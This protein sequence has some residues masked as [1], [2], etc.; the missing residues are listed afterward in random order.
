M[1]STFTPAL[2][3]E[4]PA[5]GD[6]VN[7]WDLPANNNYS[8][9]DLGVGG[10]AVLTGLTGGT[11]VLTQAQANA[12]ML[13]LTGNLSGNQV[14]AYP[15]S[16]SGRKVIFPSVT[17]NGFALYFRANSGS[18]TIGVYMPLAF[19]I[20]TPIIVT[21]A[22]VYWDY[23]GVAPGMIQGFPVD[24][25]PNGWLPC[26]G[27]LISTAQYDFLFDTIG[28]AYG[29]SGASFAVPDYRGYADVCSDNMGTAA[30]S[31]GRFFNFGPNGVTGETSHV[32]IISETPVHSHTVFDPGHNHALHDP[33]HVHPGVIAETAGTGAAPGF[34]SPF[35]NT[36]PAGTGITIS[37]A[38][39][40]I[41]LGTAGSGGAHNNVQPSRTRNAYI[42]W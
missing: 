1:A 27:R 30:G 2:H 8:L 28:Y 24:L 5:R 3:L 33:G 15:A 42:R 39:T 20:P 9:I 14:I 12:S 25:V 7:D 21:S 16:A 19:G 37:P 6:Y 4:M 38:G 36:G 11:T 18:D 40:G 41:S 22:R 34:G 26:D 32:L 23:C 35:G 10:E 31:A 13:V 17:L 29:G